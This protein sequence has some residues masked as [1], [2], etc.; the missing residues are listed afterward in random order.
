M[1]LSWWVP[2]KPPQ[3]PGCF[4]VPSYALKSATEPTRPTRAALELA[5]AWWRRFPEAP[6]IV[7]TGDNQRLGVTN[8]SVMAQYL[9]GLGVQPERVIEEDRSR[10]TFENLTNCLKIVRDAG[11]DQTTLVTHDLYTRRAVAVAR[12]MEWPDIRWVSATSK[13]EPAAG[14]KYVQTHSR[15]TILLYEIA[16]TV[17]CRFKGWL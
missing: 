6:I 16:A 5:A 17:Y 3:Q 1:R 11:Y 8:A 12:K 13:G 2:D 15:P 10:N 14:W 9:V 7:S 4:V